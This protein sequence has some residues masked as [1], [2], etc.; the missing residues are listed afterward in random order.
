MATQLT[1]VECPAGFKD[2]LAVATHLTAAETFLSQDDGYGAETGQGRPRGAG[3]VRQAP[4]TPGAV[5]LR[6]GGVYQ[7]GR[8]EVPHRHE[9]GSQAL[10]RCEI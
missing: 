9:S 6:G 1:A 8:H 2:Y 10:G 3:P 4:G 7:D 5:Q